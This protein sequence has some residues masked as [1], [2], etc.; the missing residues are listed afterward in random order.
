MLLAIR[1][2][3]APR[4]AVL[5]TLPTPVPTVSWTERGISATVSQSVTIVSLVLAS[6]L[7]NFCTVRVLLVVDLY[8]VTDHSSSSFTSTGSLHVTLFGDDQVVLQT[9]ELSS[10]NL[11][12]RISKVTLA[13]DSE[14]L[15]KSV[16][17]RG[18][19]DRMR[20]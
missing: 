5:W 17:V 16:K 10:E 11:H 4:W 20:R 12:K 15:V 8:L 6:F 3:P 13:L 1:R 19:D 7:H 18:S 2:A 9:T 14:A